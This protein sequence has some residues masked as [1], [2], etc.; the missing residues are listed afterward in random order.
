MLTISAATWED[1]RDLAQD[2]DPADAA[3]LQAAGVSVA[4]M[5]WPDD[6]QA[7]KLRGQLVALF[8]VV[9]HEQG[10]GVPWMLCTKLRDQVPPRAMAVA[11]L[12]VVRDWQARFT[13]LMNCVH[14][15]NERAIRFVEWLG[16]HVQRQPAGPGGQFFEFF[17]RRDV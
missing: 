15:P 4:R 16:F 7:L 14:A 6:T 12:R 5:P 8:G 17:W 3:E 2:L 9:E 1:M 13:M 10:F 11:A